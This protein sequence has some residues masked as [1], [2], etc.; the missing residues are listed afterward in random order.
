MLLLHAF[1]LCSDTAK[2]WPCIEDVHGIPAE[3]LGVAPAELRDHLSSG[4]AHIGLLPNVAAAGEH[5]VGST[6]T[7]VRHLPNPRT[8]LDLVIPS[9]PSFHSLCTTQT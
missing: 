8:Q 4:D 7:R 3:G 6:V 5:I 2:R 9:P 1:D